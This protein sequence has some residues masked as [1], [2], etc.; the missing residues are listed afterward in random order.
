MP[1]APTS[2]ATRATLLIN[3]FMTLFPLQIY[4][5]DLLG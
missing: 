3:L 1:A 2:K 5:D 4:D